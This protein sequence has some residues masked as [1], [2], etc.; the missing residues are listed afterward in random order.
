[1]NLSISRSFSS[2]S[3]FDTNVLKGI[4]LILLLCHHL[5]Y[6][7]DG[8]YDDVLVLGKF[9]L[10][11]QF[12]L[13]C[14]VCVA[15]FVF[16][17]GY[18][19][20]KK[21]EQVQLK[22]RD[23]YVTRFAKLML[24]YWFV[25]LL[26]VPVGFFMGRTPDVVYQDHIIGKFIADFL[27]LAWCFGFYGFNPTWWFMSCILLLYALFPVLFRLCRKYWLPLL[28]VSVLI[29]WLPLYVFE[30]LK[31]YLP[32]FLLGIACVQKKLLEKC[33]FL[34]MSGFRVG[35]KHVAIGGGIV[36]IIS[37]LVFMVRNKF[38]FPCS[39]LFD[40]V[41]A[42]LCVLTYKC[43]GYT[44]RWNNI[45]EFAG[46]HSMNIFLFHTFIFYCYFHDWI[47]ASRNPVLIFLTLFL[48]CLLIS[49]GMEQLKKLVRFDRLGSWVVERMG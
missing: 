44:G 48:S 46:R 21:Y 27:G 43:I 16:L 20:A 39:L 40:S 28:V 36:L 12:G 49:V 32:T 2:L 11:Q 17:S 5:F 13:A 45:F 26:F 8:S 23:F 34:V 7:Q 41:L 35:N 15:L 4:A 29:T 37:V 24:A 1:M 42:F 6:I 25:W 30:P 18:G 31:Y 19:L 3:L 9:P 10:V 22:A 38:P 47:Y 33:C 14:K